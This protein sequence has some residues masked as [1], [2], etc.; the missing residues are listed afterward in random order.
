MKA[1]RDGLMWL[2]RVTPPLGAVTIGVAAALALLIF[3]TVSLESQAA[4]LYVERGDYGGGLPNSLRWGIMLAPVNAAPPV[5]ML[6]RP[7]DGAW[8][9]QSNV[10]FAWSDEGAQWYDLRVGGVVH[11]TNATSM[12]L[13][14][15]DGEHTWT[16]QA[17]QG[18][19]ASGYAAPWTVKVDTEPPA[20]A[21]VA[22]V[23]GAVLTTT[24][25]PNVTIGGTASD[26]TAGLDRVEVDTG[27]GWRAASGTS[28]WTYA[29]ALPRVDNLPRTL[30]ARSFDRAGNASDV[31]QVAVTVDTVA[32]TCGTPV[33][34]RDPWVTS[35]VVY[36]WPPASDAAGILRY[37]IQIKSTRGYGDTFAVGDS[38]YVFTQAIQEGE[39]YYAWVRALDGRGNWG[40]WS[41][42]SA[43]VIPDRT[44]PTVAD[45]SIL[46]DGP[47]LHAVGT[48]LYYT[49]T[50]VFPQTF[51]LRGYSEDDRSGVAR[52]CFTRA[53]GD[54][55][56]CDVDGFPRWWQSGTPG[57]AVDTGATASGAI[58][59]TVYDR[60]GNVAR[61]QFACEL[62]GTPPD[63]RASSQPYATSRPI[64]VAWT[65]TDAQSG[66][67]S[68]ELWFKQGAAGPWTY[69]QTLPAGGDSFRFYPPG[70]VPGTYS[71]VTVARDNLGNVEP[72]ATT[73]DAQTVYD[74]NKPTSEVTWAPEYWNRPDTP[75]TLTWAATPTL[76]P[77]VE[78]RLW[79]RY[80]EG[81]WAPT[82]I[83]KTGRY[84][85]PISGTFSFDPQ[86]N[87]RYDFD[88]VAR[89]DKGESEAEPSD[90]GDRTTRY[91]TAIGPPA[92]LTSIPAVWSQNDLFAVTW[93]NPSD[94]SG[95][96][97]AYHK[98]D[99]APTGPEDG[100]WWPGVGRDRIDKL[101]VGSEGSHTLYLW[102]R[103]A[104][105][106]NGFDFGNW[107]TVSLLYDPTAPTDVS[108]A[109]PASAARTSFVVSW[110]ANTAAS[111]LLR[112]TVEYSR[113]IYSGWKQWLPSTTETSGRFTAPLA[114]AEY[115]LQ[116]TVYDRAGHSAQAQTTVYVER[117]R[118]YLP[119]LRDRWPD[120][121]RYDV[122]EPNDMPADAYGPLKSG[123]TYHSFI[124]NAEDRSDYYYFVPVSTQQVVIMLANIPDHC[125]YDLYLYKEGQDKPVAA[126]NVK[127]KG[128]SETIRHS[129]EAGRTYWI[130]V[131]S[132]YRDFSS[133]QPYRLTV[134]YK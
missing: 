110:S 103:D 73:A 126:S 131:Y 130:L 7:A 19:S 125:D 124:W 129:P 121:Y 58:V 56:S 43:G 112:Y 106:N 24:H 44:P 41:D 97:G 31:A 75:I 21:I 78:V 72:R 80:D 38:Q 32:P 76:A 101:E 49:N 20:A 37:Q 117:Q 134:T 84:R 12:V 119:V 27:D 34:D 45:P 89:D 74:K 68:V 83:S 67:G 64:P 108:I 13:P 3:C 104:A 93:T 111:G 53:F 102:L 65:A 60:A 25:L 23:S 118:A 5:P 100:I 47:Y 86:E 69:D 91:D 9:N 116:V 61:Q 82:E 14:L 26:V 57:Y 11:T 113:A 6:L 122:Y 90:A 16:V 85:E 52:V 94:L 133:T 30:K 39:S 46:V 77:L 40:A 127:G 2:Q 120:W 123:Q 10:E 70:D 50:M 18:Q 115:V 87:G 132:Y 62:D 48:T 63:S 81:D 35:T 8:K 96:V 22:P 28:P 128:G 105:G 79:V 92:H 98:L 54:Q 36:D 51:E 109:A 71:F 66:V 59:A 4:P 99:S 55:P 33:P 17:R 1:A 29:W 42:R 95:I 15:D 114:G 88:T 107:R